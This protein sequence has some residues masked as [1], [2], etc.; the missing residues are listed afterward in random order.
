MAAV[1]EE[2]FSQTAI[3]HNGVVYYANF[4]YAIN[5]AIQTDSYSSRKPNANQALVVYSSILKFFWK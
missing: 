5:L 4:Y 2:I 1:C 3:Q